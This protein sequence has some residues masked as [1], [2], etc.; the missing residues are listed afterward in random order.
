MLG[1]A[2]AMEYN[3]VS[4]LH[5]QLCKDFG[6]P[7]VRTGDGI[8]EPA[9]CCFSCWQTKHVLQLLT[10]WM[11]LILRWLSVNFF[12]HWSLWS[13]ANPKAAMRWREVPP[14]L[15]ASGKFYSVRNVRLSHKYATSQK[16]PQQN[17][18]GDCAMNFSW[19]SV[20]TEC[21][22]WKS[23]ENEIKGDQYIVVYSCTVA[24]A[25]A[26]ASVVAQS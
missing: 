24:E 9:K 5:K 13:W 11:W 10:F 18:N 7:K 25:S 22:S 21:D 17:A 26:V 1:P 8:E 16:K 12:G 6:L 3:I 14:L 2:V 23:L 19:E 4:F 15:C 20:M